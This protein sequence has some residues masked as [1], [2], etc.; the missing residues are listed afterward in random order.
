MLLAG[1]SYYFTQQMWIAIVFFSFGGIILFYALFSY[2]FFRR[3]NPDYLRSE[4]YHL[5]KQSMEQLGHKGHAIEIKDIANVSN[6][7]QLEDGT[8]EGI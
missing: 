7:Y 2:D 1:S 5:K 3:T 6:P 8:E 4:E